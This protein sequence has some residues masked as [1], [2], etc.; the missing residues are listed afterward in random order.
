M[1]S[2]MDIEENISTVES[3]QLTLFNFSY[4]VVISAL[5]YDVPDAVKDYLRLRLNAAIAFNRPPKYDGWDIFIDSLYT[6]KIA[7]QYKVMGPSRDTHNKIA[8]FGLHINCRHVENSPDPSTEFVN[9][10]FDALEALYREKFKMDNPRLALLRAETIEFVQENKVQLSEDV[11]KLLALNKARLDGFFFERIVSVGS[12][13]YIAPSELKEYIRVGLNDFL[14][15][16][17]PSW[18]EGWDIFASIGYLKKTKKRYKIEERYRYS[19]AYHK[20]I[21]YNLHINC[22]L[23][24]SAPHPATAF[25]EAV[26]DAV[27]ELYREHFK[28]ENPRLA[29]LRAET[30]RY[31][32]EHG[33]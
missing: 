9:V 10:L 12:D 19:N 11:D 3:K 27:T 30:L 28:I 4:M 7:E 15:T 21:F 2:K 32:E 13:V 1:I 17:W 8:S 33:L 31:V 16:Y 23:A 25:T 29:T 18:Y 26:F 5:N 22:R 6:D 20:S 24:K 14:Y